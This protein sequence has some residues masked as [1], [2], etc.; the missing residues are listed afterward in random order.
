MTPAQYEAHEGRVEFFDSGAGIAWMVGEPAHA[1]HERPRHRLRHL[2]E[3]I[4]Q[5]RGSP[6]ESL[7]ETEVRWTQPGSGEHRSMHPDQ[8][9]FLRPDR[10]EG[11]ISQYLD[12]G[13]DPHPDVVLEV[14]STTDVRR[15]RLKLYEAAGF[16]EVWVEV[17]DA[18]A[19]GR[20]AGLRSEMRIYLLE[21]GRYAPSQESR[22]FPGW[23]TAEI[24]RALSRCRPEAGAPRRLPRSRARLTPPR[25]KM[26]RRFSMSVQVA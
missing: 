6:I 9:L 15:N 4:A 23:R 8:M 19:P 22:A 26:Q 21:R 25:G 14:D 11:R 2:L 17:P 12:I 5:V 7:G 3:R 10:T 16:P 24:H 13:E 18:Y 20:P 1:P